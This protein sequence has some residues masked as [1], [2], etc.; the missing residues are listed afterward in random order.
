MLL[1]QM[2]LKELV[3]C[4][5][6]W[7]SM[8]RRSRGISGCTPVSPRVVPTAEDVGWQGTTLEEG[9][10]CGRPTAKD[11]QA[12]PT[13]FVTLI[14]TVY[15]GAVLGVRESPSKRPFHRVGL[16]Y[17][18]AQDIKG[19]A[20]IPRT[21]L[22]GV[23]HHAQPRG[24]GGESAPPSMKMKSEGNV[25]PGQGIDLTMK[26]VTKAKKATSPAPSEKIFNKVP[27]KT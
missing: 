11:S 26:I 15:V 10:V 4:G 9:A 22:R 21:Y 1:D 25:R 27:G 24:H 19:A 5:N 2:Y 18:D 23:G 12:T 13:N 14:P 8:R 6:V 3:D 20:S 16:E 7:R 17:A